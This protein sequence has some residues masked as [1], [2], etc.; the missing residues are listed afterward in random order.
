MQPSEGTE[1]WNTIAARLSDMELRLRDETYELERFIAELDSTTRELRMIPLATLLDHF[2]VPLRQLARS[3][4]RQVRFEIVGEQIEVDKALLE[5]LE[6]PLLH[7]LRNAIDHGVETPAQ[8]VQAGKPA[9]ATVRIVA[10]MAGQRLR[11]A[12]LRRWGRH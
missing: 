12:R 4:G 2:P 7:L 5:M 8:R 11:S 1:V 10:G 3:L 6:E 9:E